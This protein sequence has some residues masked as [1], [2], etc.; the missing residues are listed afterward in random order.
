M[1]AKTHVHGS[2]STKYNAYAYGPSC[3]PAKGMHTGTIARNVTTSAGQQG[4]PKL[5]P[6]VKLEIEQRTEDILQIK[7]VQN[8]RTTSKIVD[9][10]PSA[11]SG[12]SQLLTI[13][14]SSTTIFLRVVQKVHGTHARKTTPTAAWLAFT[15]RPINTWAA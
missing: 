10:L 13:C 12:V 11:A 2:V 14:I 7:I 9:V 3:V 4:C 15:S 5:D 8:L 1:C 6:L